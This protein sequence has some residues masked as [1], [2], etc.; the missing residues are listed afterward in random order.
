MKVKS[1]AMGE[2]VTFI[3]TAENN[4]SLTEPITHVM[5]LLAKDSLWRLLDTYEN[6][7]RK[8][9]KKT[10]KILVLSKK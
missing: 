2:S 1:I 4:A 8:N 3:K 10:K 7:C 9:S 5:D 6:N